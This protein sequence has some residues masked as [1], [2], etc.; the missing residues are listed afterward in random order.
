MSKNQFI[1]CNED[2]YAITFVHKKEFRT[3]PQNWL[4]NWIQVQLGQYIVEILQ[5]QAEEYKGWLIYDT[6]VYFYSVYEGA[7]EI[8][9]KSIPLY[10]CALW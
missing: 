3:I 6:N 8:L 5:H 10:Y 4:Q 1:L 2:I 9:H 7:I